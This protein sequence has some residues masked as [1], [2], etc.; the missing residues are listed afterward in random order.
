MLVSAEKEIIHT[1]EAVPDNISMKI[2]RNAV[3]TIFEVLSFDCKT[4][5]LVDIKKKTKGSTIDDI[6]LVVQALADRNL[7]LNSGGYSVSF[8][9]PIFS[10]AY[11]AVRD[12]ELL[13]AYLDSAHEEEEREEERK[14]ESG[15]EE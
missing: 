8:R 5:K 2:W 15:K 4:A 12:E 10:N 3:H 6:A 14:K 7:L 1:F 11:K 13:Q 9:S